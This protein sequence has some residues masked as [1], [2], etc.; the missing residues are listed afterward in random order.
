M[1][2]REH[3]REISNEYTNA[4]A[5]R[6]IQL[7]AAYIKEGILKHARLGATMIYF[8]LL[9]PGIY[10]SHSPNGTLNKY[11]PGPI[12]EHYIADIVK[13]LKKTFPDTDFVADGKLL[14]VTWA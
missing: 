2:T 7:F 10:S 14:T 4:I 6:E 11:D 13:V 5:E 3:L 12:P 1:F 9:P 8:P